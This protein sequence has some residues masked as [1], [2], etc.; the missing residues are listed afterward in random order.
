MN[1]LDME[2]YADR[3]ARDGQRV[4]D[5]LSAARL[6]LAWAEF[7]VAAREWLGGDDSRLL[8]AI[9]V[10]RTTV[11]DDDEALVDRRRRQLG[12]VGRYQ[13]FVEEQLAAL[14]GTR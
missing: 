2:L 1:R 4:A 12:A 7:E 5:E 10:L 8:E 14:R 6:R 11:G 3:L 13:A 9:G